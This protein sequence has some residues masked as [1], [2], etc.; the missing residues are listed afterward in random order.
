M[1]FHDNYFLEHFKKKQID[2]LKIEEWT[3]VP[4]S[5]YRLIFVS[6]SNAFLGH[7]SSL[8]PCLPSM[9][10]R[11]MLRIVIHFNKMVL[12]GEA[13]DSQMVMDVYTF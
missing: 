13:G 3:Y 2:L 10:G 4:L 1:S 8:F 7:H 11:D 9:M 12:P 5:L 6:L